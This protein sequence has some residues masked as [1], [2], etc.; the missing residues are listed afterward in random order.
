MNGFDDFDT[1]VQSDELA[2]SFE[3][4]AREVD[5]SFEDLTPEELA[6]FNAFLDEIEIESASLRF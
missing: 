2:Y 3:E 6:E 1:Q 4:F 5:F